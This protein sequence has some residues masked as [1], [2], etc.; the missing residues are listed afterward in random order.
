MAEVQEEGQT[1]Q[2]EV[3]EDIPFEEVQVN[4]EPAGDDP[5]MVRRKRKA[6]ALKSPPKKKRTSM[7]GDIRADPI[8]LR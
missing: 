5:T 3:E 6:M 2:H 4:K 8:V 1:S 7:R